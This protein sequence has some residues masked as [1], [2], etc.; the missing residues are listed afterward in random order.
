M[1]ASLGREAA[2]K[3]MGGV[4][5]SLLASRMRLSAEQR[6]LLVACGAGAGL[7][8][9]YN[10]P[11][12]GALFTAEVLYGCIKLPIVLP[13]L[14][15]SW[16]ATLTAWIYLPAQATY[17]GVP[18]YPLTATATVWSIVVAPVLGLFSV[19]FIRLIGWVSHHR[20]PGRWALVATLGAFRVLGAIGLWYPQ[21]FGNGKG[22]AHDA[23]LGQSGLALMLAL[24]ALKPLVTSLC[25]A[26]GASGGLFT[27][28]VPLTAL[29]TML[30]A[31]WPSARRRLA[32]PT[33]VLGVLTLVL[34]P[35]TTHAGEWLEHRKP[36][37][38]LIDE[39]TELGDLMLP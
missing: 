2:P 9:V 16:I 8:C 17:I 10:V 4:C 35:I 39:H 38:P 24:L 20:P 19:A 29:L 31:V 7:A 23:F 33:A 3:L 5:G 18:A 34:V 21:L 22:I 27:P 11:L 25:L 14:A 37:T 13:V 30:V 6:R 32:I 28:V 1:G 15:C 12:G 26:S 36:S